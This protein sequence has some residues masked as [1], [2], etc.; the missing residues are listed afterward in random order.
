MNRDVHTHI[1][2]CMAQAAQQEMKHEHDLFEFG[3][4]MCVYRI[5]VPSTC[6]C[7]SNVI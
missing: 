6:L 3:F 7:S 4:V 1:H 2:D 5:T